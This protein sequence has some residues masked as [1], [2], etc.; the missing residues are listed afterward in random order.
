MASD[1]ER[2]CRPILNRKHILTN[3]TDRIVVA[4]KANHGKSIG[5]ICSD[6]DV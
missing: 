1:Q 5:P 3:K 2:S 6:N 4:I